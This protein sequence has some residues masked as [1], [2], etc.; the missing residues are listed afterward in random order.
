MNH[1]FPHD[2]WAVVLSEFDAQSQQL[3]DLD[4]KQSVTNKWSFD[5][6]DGGVHIDLIHIVPCRQFAPTNC[7]WKIGI[8]CNGHRGIHHWFLYSIP[9]YAIALFDHTI[10]YDPHAPEH[11]AACE[12]TGIDQRMSSVLPSRCNSYDL[13]KYGFTKI[14]DPFW[15]RTLDRSTETKAN[16][17]TQASLLE[18]CDEHFIKCP[19]RS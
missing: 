7:R 1:D 13:V 18:F 5:G 8:H 6:I 16:A 9:L 17:A 19:T 12:L 3:N 11:F 2:D 10:F 15:P 4:R 14:S